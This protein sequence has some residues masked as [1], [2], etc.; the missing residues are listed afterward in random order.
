MSVENRWDDRECAGFSEERLLLYRS[1]LLGSDLSITNFAGGNT[2]AKIAAADPLSGESVE[3]LW[4][5]GSGGDLFSMKL[6]GFATLYQ[7]RVLALER[8]YRGKAHEDEMVGLYSHCTF[9][10]NP[11]ATSIDTPLHAFVPFKH[12]DHLH[13]DS[14]IAIAASKDGERLT[15]EIFQ[16][17][18]GWLPWQRPGFDLGLRIRE[19]VRANQ[20]LIGV[21]LGGHG[22][23][24]WAS[25]SKGCYEASLEVINLAAAA[26]AGKAQLKP[27]GAPAVTPLANERRR[28]FVARLVPLLRGK[29]S[30][31]QRKV[32]HFDDSQ[33]ILELVCSERAADLAALGTSCP[34]HF[35]RTKIKPLLL[36][37]DPARETEGDVGARL[38]PSLEA[39]RRDYAAYYERCKENNSPPLRD[40]YPVVILIPGVGMLT[41]AKDKPIARQAAEFY[42]NAVHVMRGAMT[43]STYVGLPEKEAFGI[44]YWQLE[45][46]KLRRLPPEKS[47][48]RKVAFITGAAGGIGSACAARML[49][50]GACVVLSDVD[51][52]VLQAVEQDLKKTFGADPVRSA[53]CDV[54]SEASV[55]KAVQQAVIEYGGLDVLVCCAGLA[56]ASSIEETTL[57]LWNRNLGV[58]AT[59]YFLVAREAYK[60]MKAQGLG[61]SIVFVASKNALAASPQA[62]AYCTSKAAELHLSRCFALEGAEG[63]IRC[64]VVNP[65]AVLKGSRIWAGEWRKERAQAYGVGEQDL[66]EYYRNRSLLKRSVYPE[67]IAEAVYFFASER[68]AKSTGNILNVDAGNATAFPR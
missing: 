40:P 30:R 62:S 47:L 16:G 48:S 18:I 54:T 55:Q 9:N 28:E 57:E 35:L 20:R 65:D 5:K 4:V 44:E 3:V 52:N 39:Y 51:S 7:D 26:L 41:F 64:N 67:D 46:A 8:R 45:E 12:I 53:V 19:L 68:S 31:E 11:R 34:D 22:L 6:D 14:V 17:R 10:L 58:L 2:S 38:D 50:E 27:F 63:G 32:A 25:T 33:D 56:S 61:G 15:R 43:L 21:V 66:E 1:N 49:E 23:M 59:G 60:V 42:V 36:D 37:F 24:T 29:L 13:P